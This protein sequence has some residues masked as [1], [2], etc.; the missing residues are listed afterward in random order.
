MVDAFFA[1]QMITNDPSLDFREQMEALMLREFGSSRRRGRARRSRRS[2]RTSA[3]RLH[4]QRAPRRTPTAPSASSRAPQ[5]A[6]QGLQGLKGGKQQKCN[7]C[8]R[9]CSWI[10]VTCTKGPNALWPCH[11]ETTRGRGKGDGGLTHHSCF[12]KH[13]E[14]PAWIPRVARRSAKRARGGAASEPPCSPCDADDVDDE[15]DDDDDDE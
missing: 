14:D 1:L 13:E 7:I 5:L 6:G 3:W 9:K 12:A 2:S 4:L 11:P 8:N 15:I 10:C